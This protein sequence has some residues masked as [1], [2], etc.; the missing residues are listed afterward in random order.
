[1]M[2]MTS[3]TGPLVASLLAMSLAFATPP[4]SNDSPEK[5]RAR[6]ASEQN[7]VGK[8]KLEV[9]LAEIVLDQS[10]KQ[11]AEGDFDKGE[12]GVKETM[13]LTENAFKGLFSTH[14]DPRSKP[15]GFKEM[16]MRLRQFARKMEDLR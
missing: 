1:M 2:S 15:A 4:H 8:A 3:M 10:C 12:A 7:P 5:L 16:E 13:T 11:Y 6:I 14:K 9:Q